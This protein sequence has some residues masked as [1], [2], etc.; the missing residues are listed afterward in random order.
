MKKFLAL[1]MALLLLVLTGCGVKT[2]ENTSTEPPEASST[3]EPESTTEKVEPLSYDEY[4]SELR[5]FEIK[6]CYYNED[7]Y[8]EQWDKSILIED[9]LIVGQHIDLYGVNNPD[10]F[11][12]KCEFTEGRLYIV[13]HGTKT[14]EG[15]FSDCNIYN[16]S[17]IDYN[18]Y[19]PFSA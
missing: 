14:V 12:C 7:I 6:P 8:P 13:N 5:P 19:P 18:Y 15:F 9:S 4:F 3:T 2:P 10:P 11:E 1:F 16:E 17:G